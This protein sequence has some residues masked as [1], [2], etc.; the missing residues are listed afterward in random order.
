MVSDAGQVSS[1]LTSAATIV[2]LQKFLK[3][4]DFYQQFVKAFPGSDKYAHWLI[5][6]ISS[7]VAAAGIHIVWNWDLLHGGQATATIPDLSS[8]VHGV[9]D[10][11]KVYIM[12]HTIYEAT[13]HKEN[14]PTT[15]TTTITPV[16]NV[17]HGGTV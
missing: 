8:M 13:T 9:T 12:Q 1:F 14:E 11:F 3:T 15:I 6:G 5:A 4:R 10:W 7:I 2:A 16:I 17:N